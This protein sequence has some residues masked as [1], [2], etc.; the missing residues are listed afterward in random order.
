MVVSRMGWRAHVCLKVAASFLVQQIFIHSWQILF[1][2]RQ[3][4][5]YIW[6]WKFLF[7][8]YLFNGY[9]C[10][11][12]NKQTNIFISLTWNRKHKSPGWVLKKSHH[13]AVLFLFRKGVIFAQESEWGLSQWALG[14]RLSE[15]QPLFQQPQVCLAVHFCHMVPSTETQ[16]CLCQFCLH[17]Y[18]LSGN[19][20]FHTVCK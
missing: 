4:E 18:F 9:L 20:L 5:I 10:R 1:F 13:F 3:E 8:F 14:R 17:T 15:H 11:S 6:M 2:S 16:Q 19:C 12:K 7:C